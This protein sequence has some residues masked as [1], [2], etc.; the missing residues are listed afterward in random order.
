M[1][2]YLASLHASCVPLLIDKNTSATD[3]ALLVERF[4]PGYF[5]GNLEFEVGSLDWS[6]LSNFEEFGLWSTKTATLPLSDDLGLLLGTSG[7]TDGA[8][9]VRLSY[10]NL[11]DNTAAIIASL[12]LSA[13]DR[14][15]T[16][17]PMS[18]TYGL[19]ILHT[20]LAIGGS[21][22]LTED[23]VIS[24]TWQA[25]QANRPTSFSVF[26]IPT[27]YWPNCAIFQS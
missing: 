10:A 27:S 4:R 20:H 25:F 19:S 2:A 7:S 23:S 9:F 16:T 13:S 22:V 3:V 12:R 17:L 14:A 11:I 5:I 26:R 8:K 18:Y 24:V 15:I 21:T 1:V 6:L